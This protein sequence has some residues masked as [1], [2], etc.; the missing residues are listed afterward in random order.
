MSRVS[1]QEYDTQS[2]IVY[3]DILARPQALVLYQE[4]NRQNI[5][6]F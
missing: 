3:G 1:F 2:I 6:S 5:V 4:T